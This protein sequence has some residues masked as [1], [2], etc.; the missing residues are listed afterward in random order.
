MET[1]SIPDAGRRTVAQADRIWRQNPV[2]VVLGALA[3][4]LVIGL[5]LRAAERDRAVELKERL[6]E[7][8][9]FLH[10]LVGSLGKATKKGY[11][12]SAAA[13]KDAVE[14]AVDA[15]RDI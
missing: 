12:K 1:E 3:T 5:I 4:G 2:P 14:T 10:D 13:V 11:R 6:A 9:G 7:T 8:E 15:A